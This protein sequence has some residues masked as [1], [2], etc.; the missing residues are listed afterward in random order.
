MST[1]LNVSITPALLPNT[2]SVLEQYNTATVVNANGREA[3]IN[4][5]GLLVGE[6]FKMEP[7]AGGEPKFC[8][9]IEVTEFEGKVIAFIEDIENIDQE[10]TMRNMNREQKRR[11]MRRNKIGKSK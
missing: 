11:Y 1:N 3:I 7:V 5:D 2:H 10:L 9:V 8:K 6:V 4:A